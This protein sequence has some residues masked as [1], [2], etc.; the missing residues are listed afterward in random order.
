MGRATLRCYATLNDFL[1]PDRR[2]ADVERH[3]SGSPGVKDL[4]EAAGVPHVEVGLVLVNGRPVDFSHRV[5]DGDRVSAYPPF[6]RIDMRD[7]TTVAA[8]LPDPILFR[9]DGHLG[10]LARRLR[11]LGFDTLYD[12]DATDEEL[13]GMSSHD[14]VLLS[15]DLG[16][17]KRSEVKL[18]Y[19]LR[20]TRPANQTAE[21]VE[22]FDL[23][24]VARPF[25]RCTACNG[26][27]RRAGCDEVAGRIPEAVAAHHRDFT[28][29]PDCRRVYWPGSHYA[30]LKRAVE[31]ALA[32]AAST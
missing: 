17:L 32:H 8:P 31:A 4:I 28:V 5:V 15:R 29:C 24:R 30:N 22:R 10:R 19:F 9:L 13:A 3:F 12:P 27:L 21:V 11:L 18:G 2:G 23:S 26:G 1:P 6:T 7:V 20:S 16:L 14:R 25:T